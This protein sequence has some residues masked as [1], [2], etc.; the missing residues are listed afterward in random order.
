MRDLFPEIVPAEAVRSD[1]LRILPVDSDAMEPTLG[2]RD[3]VLVAPVDRFAFDGLYVL[4]D[5]IGTSVVRARR[6]IGGEIVISRDNP[7]YDQGTVMTQAAF[8][9]IV[10]AVVVADVK[11]RAPHL[12]RQA[13]DQSGEVRT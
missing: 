11:V 4:D 9:E 12:L 5:R 3:F 13:M 6:R 2:A 1:R 8:D 10:L 7:L